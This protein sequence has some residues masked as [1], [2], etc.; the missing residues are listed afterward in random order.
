[1]ATP[2]GLGAFHAAEL[3]FVFDTKVYGLVSVQDDDRPLVGTI[4]GY[5]SRFA[6]TGDPNGEGAITWPVFDA[7][8]DEHIVLDLQPAIASGLGADRCD[9]WDS[10]IGE[11]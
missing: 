11:S 3:L 10:G 6:A 5:W 4:M 9:F 2:P 8:T 7:L 1:M